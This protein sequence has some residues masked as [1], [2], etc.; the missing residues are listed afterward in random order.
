MNRVFARL[1][2]A[3]LAVFLKEVSGGLRNCLNGLT[4]WAAGGGIGDRGIIH[5]S[6]SLV[7]CNPR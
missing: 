4:V 2:M 7:I 3:A 5:K 1:F 6:L